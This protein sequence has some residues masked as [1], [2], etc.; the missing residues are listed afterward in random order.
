LFIIKYA[1]NRFTWIEKFLRSGECCPTF[2][3]IK[4]EASADWLRK[5]QSSEVTVVT[6]EELNR[7][8][9]EET[10]SGPEQMMKEFVETTKE[11]TEP[12]ADTKK[13]EPEQESKDESE[14]LNESFVDF[15]G[16]LIR[17]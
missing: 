5:Y 1:D 14:E 12:A 2:Q 10:E 9:N 8:V 4:A 3:R 17:G 11:K 7:M 6:A 15:C 16:R 13:T